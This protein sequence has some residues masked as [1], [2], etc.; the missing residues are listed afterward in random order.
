MGVSSFGGAV[1]E[2]KKQI[3]FVWDD[4][5]KKYLEELER[6]PFGTKVVSCEAS[7]FLTHP[8]NFLPDIEH[9]VVAAGMAIIKQVIM[10]NEAWD[11]SL[12]F[13]PLESQKQLIRLLDLSTKS[14]H[15]IEIALNDDAKEIDLIECNGALVEFKA[16]IGNI[17]LIGLV[18][19]SGKPWLFFK[20]LKEGVIQFFKIHLQQFEIE[21][22]NGKKIKTAASGVFV[23]EH[24]RQS[25][26]SRM[27][28]SDHSRRDGQVLLVL[29][30]PFSVIEYIKFLFSII[31][32]SSN[33][34]NL[35]DAIGIIKSREI[36]VNAVESQEAVLDEYSS[37]SLPAKFQ[38][39]DH[40]LRIN[41][42]KKFW[43]ENVKKSPDKETVKIDNLPDEKEMHKYLHSH[44]PF[45]SYASEE[46][47]KELFLSLRL[48]A[49]TNMHYV[50][51]M[52][53]S[54][55]LASIGL[56]ANS[57]AVVIGA[58]LLA[59]LMA[60]IVSFAMGM[61]RA[62]EKML[63]YSLL[64]IVTGIALALGA[65]AAV[66][67]LL[68]ELALTNEMRA[69]I[70]PNLLDMGVAIF[71][72]VAAAYS[73]SFKEI[74]QSLA[75]VAIAVALVPPLSVAGIGLGQGNMD[76]FFGAL[77]LFFTNLV[78]ISVAATL[79]FQ[80]LGFSNVVKSRKSMLIVSALLI[81]TVFP[82]FFSYN[83][84]IKSYEMEK[85]IQH[86]RFLVNDKYVIIK[87]AS[88]VDRGNVVVVDLTLFVRESLIRQDLELLKQKLQ[89]QIKKKLF[90]RANVEY[91]L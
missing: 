76:I 36:T 82:L 22:A 4:N 77:L 46:R 12:A 25:I 42:G 32:F 6:N 45:F 59:P 7:L 8:E 38:I 61:L 50:V 86:S 69:R 18:S 65:S 9:V 60:P 52:I 78:G 71:S 54:T 19:Q 57:S 62:D 21:T 43:E 74:A 53:L 5:G 55:L 16:T 2:Y 58:M 29:V 37:V 72:G 10:L 79:T 47:F 88:V 66:A 40:S 75:G 67:L 73:K 11:F 84:I 31:T 64:K 27:I 56:F 49:V 85:F 87:T 20:N 63:E 90:I 83:K 30:S 51:L 24:G 41:A 34:K 13:L 39:M 17:P 26:L 3:L 68:P 81:A 91:I 1:M 80:L 89:N 48:D 70:N 15:N 33:K 23:L 35:P 28:L 14:E 44:I